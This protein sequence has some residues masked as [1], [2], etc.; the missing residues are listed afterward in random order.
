MDLPKTFIRNGRKALSGCLPRSYYLVDF[1]SRNDRQVMNVEDRLEYFICFLYGEFRLGD[2]GNPCPDLVVENNLV[3]S[4]S[5]F[6]RLVDQSAVKINGEV[7]TDPN[8]E[9]TP[10]DSGKTIQVGKRRFIKIK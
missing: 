9:L 1:S 8:L 3:P 4:K 10:A 5:Q 2:D 6:R 7:L